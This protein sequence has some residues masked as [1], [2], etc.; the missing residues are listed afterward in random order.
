MALKNTQNSTKY[1]E[2]KDK[3]T[4]AFQS[5]WVYACIQECQEPPYPMLQQSQTSLYLN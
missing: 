2:S 3:T 1:N 5:L 4:I